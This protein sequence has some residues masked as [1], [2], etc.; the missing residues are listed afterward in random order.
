MNNHILCNLQDSEFLRTY[1]CNH[2]HEN[3][4]KINDYRY[5]CKGCGYTFGLS[6]KGTVQAIKTYGKHF[7][8]ADAPDIKCTELMIMEIIT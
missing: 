6:A 3:I 5:V 4:E 7:Y 1:L 2:D 8:S